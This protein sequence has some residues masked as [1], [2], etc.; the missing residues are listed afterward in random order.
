VDGAIKE[1]NTALY[2]NRNSA[3]THLALGDA[4]NQQGNLVAA[5]KQYQDAIR[6]KPETA[7]AYLRMADIREGRGDIEHSI[8][9]LRSVLE[10]VPDNSQLYER[11]ATDSLR[12]EKIDDAIRNYEQVLSTTPGNSAAAQGL[13]R[14]LYL[15]CQKDASKAFFTSND[16]ERA[17]QIMDKAIAMNPD[18]MELRLAQAKL[19]AMS[20]E[21][22][23][24]SQIGT[25][26]TEGEKIAYAEALLAQNKFAEAKSQM[27]QLINTASNDKQLLAVADLCV[28]IKDLDD[29]SAAY[30]KAA[31][32]PGAAARA[33]RGLDQVARAREAAKEDLTLANDLSKR[34]QLQSAVDRYHDA[35]FANPTDSN[36]R[37]NL[38]LTIER[39]RPDSKALKE[40]I[41]QYRGYLDLNPSIAPKDAEKW[42][43]HI[44]KLV[45]RAAK[46]EE[47]EKHIASV[48]AP[49]HAQ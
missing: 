43:K 9:E 4:Y 27:T 20:G 17:Q 3:P 14:A 30:S 19:R 46:L 23:D 38:G 48:P 24:L 6:I 35:I 39:M 26:K 7:D 34:N 42:D 1:F 47:K 2:Q 10:L 16:F 40:A 31:T 15:K 5:L 36:A 12:V 33:K 32:M 18:D 41:A 25:P 37:V 49:P 22:V 13:T 29:A 44:G 28:M 21:K 45:A 11:I 8:A